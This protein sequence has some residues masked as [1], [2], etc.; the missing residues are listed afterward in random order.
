MLADAFRLALSEESDIVLLPTAKDATTALEI[1]ARSCP[2]V[3]L[4]DA[5]IPGMD[6]VAVTREIRRASPSTEVLM[7]SAAPDE[8]LARRVARSG[9]GM[10]STREAAAGLAEILR[11]A[12][13]GR[14]PIST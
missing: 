2:D 1:C 14:R 11:S 9:Y 3:V 13:A 8:S 5:D 7:M 10:V 4:V 12:A 6:C